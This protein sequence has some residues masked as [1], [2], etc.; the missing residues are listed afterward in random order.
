MSAH[1][2]GRDSTTA[3]RATAKRPPSELPSRTWLSRHHSNSRGRYTPRDSNPRYRPNSAG[4][5]AGPRPHGNEYP[6]PHKQADQTNRDEIT[7]NDDTQNEPTTQRAF[8]YA[9]PTAEDVLAFRDFLS[10]KCPQI[11]DAIERVAD[12]LVADGVDLSR[13]LDGDR[14]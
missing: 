12:A 8:P 3:G 13:L 6:T 7:M 14:D 9:P 5:I 1:R 2:H 4:R 11:L 10:Q